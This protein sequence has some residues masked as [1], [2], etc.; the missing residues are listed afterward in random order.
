[1]TGSFTAIWAICAVAVA[2]LVIW[3]VMIKRAERR[4]GQEHPQ[5][6]QLRGVVQGGLH[7]GGGRSVAPTR[8]AP[9]PEGGGDPPLPE[10][11]D[12]ALRQRGSPGSGNPMDL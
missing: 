5:H 9:V 12:A 3:L 8:D 4:P 6:D 2:G 7:V 11:Q 1:M 10:E